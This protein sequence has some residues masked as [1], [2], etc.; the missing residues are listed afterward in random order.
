MDFDIPIKIADNLLI[1]SN[2][3]KNDFMNTS[4][5]SNQNLSMFFWI[6]KNFRIK[7]HDFY[8]GFLFGNE[9][10]SQLQLYCV[11]KSLENEGERKIFNDEFIKVITGGIGLEQGSVKS[12]ENK[13]DNVALIILNYA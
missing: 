6:R 12:I 7:N 2:F 1:S 4:L 3:S 5:Y 9:K 13:R 11:D 8:I 10:I